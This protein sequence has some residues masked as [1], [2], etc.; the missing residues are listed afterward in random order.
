MFGKDSKKKELIK[1][2]G[3]VYLDIE[4]EFGI[5]AGDFPDIQEM[6]EKLLHHDFLK[7]HPLKKPLLDA[8]DKMLAEDIA[9]LMAMIPQV[10]NCCWVAKIGVC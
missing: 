8:V 3:N 5:P 7:F 6:Q 2:L 10:N 1:G 4:R 9:K